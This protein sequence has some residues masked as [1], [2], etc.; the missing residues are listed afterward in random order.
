M[1]PSKPFYKSSTLYA[2]LVS[3]LA[4]VLNAAGVESDTAQAWALEFVTAAAPIVG[5]LADLW[6]GWR[7]S[8]SGGQ[9]PL[10]LTAETVDDSPGGTSNDDERHA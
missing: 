10:T 3:I 9:Q 5:I 8:R 6:A 4:H 1:I 7:R 2:L